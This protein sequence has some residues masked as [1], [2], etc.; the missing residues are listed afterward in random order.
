[1]RRNRNTKIIATLGP[2]S[3]DYE[4]IKALFL[5]GADVFRLNMSHGDHAQ[6]RTWIEIIRNIERETNRPIGVMVDLQGPKLR[7]GR[8]KD[9]AVIL[10][11]EA[12]F[13]LDLDEAPGDETRVT[14]PHPEIF[15]ALSP[16]AEILLDDGKIRLRITESAPDKARCTVVVGGRLSDRK[17]VN[18]PDVTL[19]I[20]ALSDKDKSD[21]QAALELGAD[22]IALSFVQRP[23]DVA[24]AR[25]LVGG[26]AGV[27]AK[28]EKPAALE[29]LGEIVALSD[30]LMVARGDLGVE[31]AVED[32]PGAQKRIHRV[33]RCAGK[34]VVVATQMMESMIL[35]PVPTRAEV[36]D[37]ANAVFEG[38]DAVM[39]SA[40][41]ASGA[42]PLEAVSTMN[43]IAEKIE[44]DPQYH[45]MLDAELAEPE[46]TTADAICAAARDVAVTVSA[47]AI[48]TFTSTGSTALRAARERPHFPILALTPHFSTAR[49]LTLSWGL[50]CVKTGDPDSFTQVVEKTCRIALHEE[51][52]AAGEYLVIIAGVP[53]GVAGT[54]NTLRVTKIAGPDQTT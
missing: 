34:P 35:S 43:R 11:E 1:M 24:E 26:R 31:M 7:I 49:R 37:V 40:E 12:S 27:L 52:A 21:L 17:G 14:L 47:K 33:A 39:L 28:I 8:F 42:W 23:E 53:F 18:F 22:W 4:M 46:E 10:L 20:A 48:V 2:S 13:Q 32:V 36:S 51:F 5:A 29:V 6:M 44:R 25:R 15:A 16:G 30:A 38:A 3:A 19:P 41:S 45:K 54:T 50:H 9:G